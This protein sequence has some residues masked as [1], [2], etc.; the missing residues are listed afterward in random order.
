MTQTRTF[1]ML[2]HGYFLLPSSQIQKTCSLLLKLKLLPIFSGLVIALTGCPANLLTSENRRYPVIAI[3]LGKQ[4]QAG[5]SRTETVQPESLMTLA[6]TLAKT[7]GEL[8]V[9]SLCSNN[10]GFR[11]AKFDPAPTEPLKPEASSNALIKASQGQKLKAKQNQYY[12]IDLPDFKKAKAKHD[13]QVT[14]EL[15]KFKAQLSDLLQPRTCPDVS[16]LSKGIQQLDL[17]AA[18]PTPKALKKDMYTVI[19]SDGIDE[20]K[21]FKGNAREYAGLAQSHLYIVTGD[22]NSQMLKDLR[23]QLFESFDSLVSVLSSKL[24]G[25]L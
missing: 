2:S 24:V 14:R 13:Q 18:E 11:R 12:Q 5:V 4:S 9:G 23:P 17:I 15:D 21:S 3:I 10:K 25:E 8:R 20:Y 16:V 22:W 19:I 1:V 6:S 7:G